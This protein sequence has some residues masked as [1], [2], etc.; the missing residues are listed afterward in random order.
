MYWK[1]KNYKA[2]GI[3]WRLISVHTVNFRVIVIIWSHRT[4][5]KFKSMYMALC[6]AIELERFANFSFLDKLKAAFLHNK[7][8]Q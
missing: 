6:S 7:L 4:F 2:K 5:I 1:K 8:F 3:S